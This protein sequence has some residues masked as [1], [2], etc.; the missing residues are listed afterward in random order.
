[1]LEIFGLIMIY[2][3]VHAVVILASDKP[4]VKRTGYEKSIIIVALIT[5]ILFI[6][7]SIA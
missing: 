6:I 3:W 1:M 7:G 4:K 5:I 2:S